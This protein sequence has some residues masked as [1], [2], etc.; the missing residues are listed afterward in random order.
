MKMK[1]TKIHCTFKPIKEKQHTT[2]FEN[3]FLDK[4]LLLFT[5]FYLITELIEILSL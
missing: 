4:V 5:S 1:I 2:T 3:L